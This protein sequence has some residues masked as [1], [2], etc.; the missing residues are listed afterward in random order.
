MCCSWG[1]GRVLLRR[2]GTSPTTC[3]YVGRVRG[4]KGAAKPRWMARISSWNSSRNCWQ[5]EV[6]LAHPPLR[7]PGRGHMQ[8]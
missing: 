1:T 2:G 6:W 7:G 5:A 3:A 4:D 8:G